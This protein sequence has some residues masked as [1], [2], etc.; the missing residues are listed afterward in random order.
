MNI[1]NSL[2]EEPNSGHSSTESDWG[3]PQSEETRR[4]PNN[5]INVPFTEKEIITAV[6]NLK[7]IK[8][9]GLNNILNEQL[10]STIQVMS[11][12][13]VKLFN[14]IFDTG[15]V[16]ES[17]AIGNILPIFKNKGNPNLPEN[18]RPITLLSCFGKLFT[19]ILNTRITQFLEDNGILNSCQ[20][21]FRK[22]FSTSDNLFIIQSLIEISKANKKKLFCAFIDFKQAFDKVW[23][24]GLWHKLQNTR[25][26]AYDLYNTCTSI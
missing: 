24:D 25:I 22:G 26:D 6:K 3:C 8:S 2:N 15:L 17:W 11:P 5:D 18:Y 14:I 20:A 19:S 10:K 1:L 13:Y 23:R 9:E 4:P 16:P 21:G 7:N 12:I